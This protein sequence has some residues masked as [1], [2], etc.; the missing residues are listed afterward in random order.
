MPH[1]PGKRICI[2]T[3]GLAIGGAEKQVCLLATGLHARG[4]KVE[5][6]S[7]LPAEAFLDELAAAGVQVHNLG[8]RKGVPDPRAIARL[9]SLFR[10]FRPRIAHCHMVHANLLGRVSRIFAEVPVLISTAHS[11]IEGG[12]WR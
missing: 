1:E 3:T 7:L 11:I 10:S 12:L 5:V 9:A 4:W 6:A 8:M 2:V